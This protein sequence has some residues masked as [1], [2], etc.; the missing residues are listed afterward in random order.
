M[1][2]L[3]ELKEEVASYRMALQKAEKDKRDAEESERQIKEL[4]RCLLLKKMMWLMPLSIQYLLLVL[5]NVQ[6]YRL[7]CSLGS[8]ARLSTLL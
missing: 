5:R 6:A 2:S 1:L 7:K 8:L 4:V 3:I